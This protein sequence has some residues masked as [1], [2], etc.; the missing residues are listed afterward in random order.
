MNTTWEE[1]W[2]PPKHYIEYV[3]KYY[4][5]Y[6]YYIEYDREVWRR[7]YYEQYEYYIE[8]EL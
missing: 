7:N 5:Q 8:Y 3:I 4:E 1:H 2:T 6:E